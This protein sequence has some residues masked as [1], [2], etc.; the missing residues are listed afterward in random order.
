MYN[1]FGLCN[2]L[3]DDSRDFFFENS[4]TVDA[5]V[6]SSHR[7]SFKMAGEISN[8][9]HSLFESIGGRKR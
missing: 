1:V 5:I 3:N 2:L 9:K 8:C 6:V 4:K 7:P